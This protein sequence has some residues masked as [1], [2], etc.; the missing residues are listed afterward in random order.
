MT[1]TPAMIAVKLGRAAPEP[2]SIQEQQWEMDID[3]A[4]ML[5]ENRAEEL[6]VD[7]ATISELKLD[8]VV[9][10]AVAAY[11]KRPDD[12][13][14]VSITVDDGTTSRSYQSGKGRI[15][16]LDE[17]WRMLGL[18]E[19]ESGAF[20]IDMVPSLGSAHLPWCSL[21]FGATYCSCGVDI[22]GKP[23]FELG[24]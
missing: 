5:I 24:E 20:A 9:R 8:Y 12:A 6:G 4:Y 23:I 18:V 17:W 16:I 1:V 22:A 3:D 7:M 21:A 14:Q 10:E 15:S 13:T 11:I 2:G 19:T